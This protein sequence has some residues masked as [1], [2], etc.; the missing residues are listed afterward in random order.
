MCPTLF[1]PLDCNCPGSSVHEIFQAGVLEWVAI[2]RPGDLPDP[3]IEPMSPE[4]V[5]CIVERFFTTESRG[6]LWA[7]KI[8]KPIDIYSYVG[9]ARPI[10]KFDDTNKSMFF[11]GLV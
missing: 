5:S 8:K 6:K 7:Y 9:T 11:Q 3:W 2:P 4:P 1:D 10:V